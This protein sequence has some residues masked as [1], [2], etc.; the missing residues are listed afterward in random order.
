MISKYTL[1]A[2][3]KS[4]FSSLCFWPND[5]TQGTFPSHLRAL[6]VFI[7]EHFPARPHL[8]LVQDRSLGGFPLETAAVNA[9]YP[10][11]RG[12]GNHSSN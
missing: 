7:P 1:T 10:T 2:P 4:V 8:P 11:G 3:V 9:A 12:G 5:R 6:R